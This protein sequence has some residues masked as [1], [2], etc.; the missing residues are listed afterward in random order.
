MAKVWEN[1]KLVCIKEND[2]QYIQF[3]KLLKYPQIKHCYTLKNLN[4]PPIYKDEKTLKNSYKKICDCLNLDENKIVKPH[5]THTSNVEVVNEVINFQD[6]DGVLTNKEEIVLVTTSAD[7]IS[8]LM[9]DPVKK[10]IGSIH[11]GWRGTLQGIAKEAVLKM[12][13][14]YESNPEDIICC[15]CPSI[16][17]CHF[18]VDEDVKDLFYEKYKNLQQINNIIKKTKIK[19]GKQKYTIDTVLI[20]ICLLKKLGLKEENIIDSNICTVCNKNNFHSYRAEKENS[21][22]NAAIISIKKES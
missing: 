9:F 4:F 8:L 2:I 19:D 15:I 6:V 14:K 16:R 18:E 7:C 22:R 10:V 12:I 11:S 5:Q 17:S 1:E 3:K 20:N 13:E 21:G